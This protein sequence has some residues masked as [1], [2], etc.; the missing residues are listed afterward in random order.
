MLLPC[1]IEK[2]LERLTVMVRLPAA[3]AVGTYE[4][5]V[6]TGIIVVSKRIAVRSRCI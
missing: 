2:Q 5:F 6:T 4:N 3:A 1:H